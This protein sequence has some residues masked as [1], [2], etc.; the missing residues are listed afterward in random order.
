MPTAEVLEAWTR[1]KAPRLANINRH[2]P[3][4]MKET[5][6]RLIFFNLSMGAAGAANSSRA[7]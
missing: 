6:L 1:A 2:N 5:L 7:S 4:I 3:A